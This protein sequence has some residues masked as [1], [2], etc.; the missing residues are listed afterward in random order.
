MTYWLTKYTY[1]RILYSTNNYSRD[2]QMFHMGCTEHPYGLYQDN[3]NKKTEF[4]EQ[5]VF[6]TRK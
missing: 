4:I 5:H 2:G 3:F 1:W 6:D